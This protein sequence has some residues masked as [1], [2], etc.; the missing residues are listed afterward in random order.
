MK[1][2]IFMWLQVIYISILR[3][4]FYFS[5]FLKLGNIVLEFL[6][7]STSHF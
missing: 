2:E 4:I 6:T 1:I 7:F 5:F 3:H